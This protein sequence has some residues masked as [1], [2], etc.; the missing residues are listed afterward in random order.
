MIRTLLLAHHYA[1]KNAKNITTE[2]LLQDF[3]ITKK[4]LN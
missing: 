3:L 2:W 1:Q 4:D